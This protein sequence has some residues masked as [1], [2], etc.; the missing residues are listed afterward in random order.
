[1][2]YELLEF[3]NFGLS[4]VQILFLGLEVAGLIGGLRPVHIGLHQLVRSRNVSAQPVAACWLFSESMLDWTAAERAVRL[5][6][7]RS[8]CSTNCGSGAG[9]AVDSAVCGDARE[10][11]WCLSRDSVFSPI[12]E[13]AL[14]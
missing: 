10:L 1:V 11:A 14:R 7:W 3:P 4:E 12:E 8:S 5:S 13:A 2:A 9:S 6:I